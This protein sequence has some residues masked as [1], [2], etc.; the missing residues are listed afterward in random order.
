MTDRVRTHRVVVAITALGFLL[1]LVSC[2]ADSA[3]APTMSSLSSATRDAMYQDKVD[4][5]WAQ[6]H[7]EFPDAVRPETA[8]VRFVKPSEQSRALVQCLARDGFEVTEVEGTISASGVT[9]QELPYELSLYSCR[10]A[11]PIDPAYEAPLSE[12]ESRYLY[13]YLTGELTECLEKHGY[14]IGTPPSFTVF[15]ESTSNGEAPWSP[16]S[17]VSARSD[18]NESIARDLVRAC[19]VKPAGLRD[20]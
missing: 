5:L 4:S 19:P 15:L 9:G 3:P 13:D 11:Y 12:A 18:L 14:E 10:A 16:W 7:A 6:V 1:S 8:V 2:S 20:G 17:E